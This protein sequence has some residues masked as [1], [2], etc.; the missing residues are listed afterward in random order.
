MEK[1]KNYDNCTTL[2]QLLDV[3]YGK[4]GTITRELFDAETKEFCIAQTLKEERLK[5]GITQ[6][7]LA[8]RMGTKKTYISRVETGRQNLN[9]TTLFRLFDCL[10]K[11]V[12]ISVL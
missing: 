9:L 12:A 3:E 8:D 11:R 6:Q 10:G 5:A 1:I 2:D 7:E 4:P